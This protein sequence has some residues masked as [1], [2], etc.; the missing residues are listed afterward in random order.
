M[1]TS[2][3]ADSFRLPIVR[4]HGFRPMKFSR[5]QSIMRTYSLI[6]ISVAMLLCGCATQHYTKGRGDV[7][8][9]ILRQAI[10][11]GGSPTTTNGLPVISTRWR[12][13]EDDHGMEICLI[14]SDYDRVELFLNLAFAGLPQ[15]GPKISADGINRIHE[16]RMS[17]QGG[18]IQLTSDDAGA[19]AVIVHTYVGKTK[20]E[21]RVD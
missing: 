6:S 13:S 15:Y 14:R 11:Y 10:S 12:Y 1:N 3:G 8:Q 7:G 4:C 19:G 2:S 20:P 21:P 5:G 18:G 17:P 9:F 16:Y